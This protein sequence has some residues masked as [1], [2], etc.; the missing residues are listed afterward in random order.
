[1]AAYDGNE[2]RCIECGGQCEDKDSGPDFFVNDEGEVRCRPCHVRKDLALGDVPVRAGRHYGGYFHVALDEV[3]ENDDGDEYV[4]A[5]HLSPSL[6]QYDDSDYDDEVD[7]R[8]IALSIL[9]DPKR[10]SA[11]LSTT[12][13]FRDLIAEERDGDKWQRMAA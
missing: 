7:P 2:G 8:L 6:V 3:M 10:S 1:M 4:N 9:L 12:R 13:T 11:M 5:A